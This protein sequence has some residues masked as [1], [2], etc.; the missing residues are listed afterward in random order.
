MSEIT[1]LYDGWPLARQP[2]SPA[3]LHLSEL[4]ALLPG[5]VRAIVA[6]PGEPLDPL[7]DPTEA[8]IVAAQDNISARLNW[9]Q[10]ILPAL[11]RELDVQAI[12]LTGGH[13]ALFASTPGILS[14]T[15]FAENPLAPDKLLPRRGLRSRLREALGEGGRARASGILWPNDLPAPRSEVPLIHLPA[16][17]HPTFGDRQSGLTENMPGLELPET[18]ILYHGPHAL[19]DLQRLLNAWTWAAG[20]IGSYYPL[21]LVGM[22]EAERK[23]IEPLLDIYQVGGTVR[24]LPDLPLSG[25]VRLYQNCS[26]L[27]HP[28]PINPWGNPVR[29]ALA[30]G[31]PVVALDSSLADALVGPAAYLVSG[32]ESG[33]D[34]SRALGAA[35]L[36]V[37]VEEPV[38]NL[39]TEAAGQRVDNW[40]SADFSAALLTAYR[41]IIWP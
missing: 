13:P 5:E 3:A 14:P 39:L 26:A 1:I 21:L 34:S 22:G 30:C 16:V 31:K 23:N 10:S 11:A 12:H 38:A 8:Q 29:V 36:T 6:L 2:N 18:F 17:V 19:P 9:E 7:P 41:Q 4:L 33:A 27:F 28:A 25:L 32:G 35:L 24:L 40:R 20:T 15:R 37:I